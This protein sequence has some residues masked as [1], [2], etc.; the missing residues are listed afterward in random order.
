MNRGAPGGTWLGF[1]FE[2]GRSPQLQVLGANGL[3]N[4]VLAPGRFCS[5]AAGDVD[6]DGDQDLYLGDYDGGGSAEPA[7]STS[8]TGSGST[9]A[10]APSPTRTRRA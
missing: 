3:P 4:G 7:G 8:T 9:T 10:P 6:S 1:R 5:I 2:A